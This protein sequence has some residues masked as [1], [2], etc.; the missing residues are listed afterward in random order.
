MY[1]TDFSEDST[2]QQQEDL[3]YDGDLPQMKKCNDYHFTFKNDHLCASGQ[4]ILTGP[5]PQEKPAQNKTFHNSAMA[6]AWDK[7]TKN[8]VYK[9]YN[10]ENPSTMALHI[11]ANK[12]DVSEANISNILYHCLSKEQILRGQ[13]IHCE[14]LPETSSTDSVDEADVIKNIISRCVKKSCHKEQ[15]SEFTG[16][17]KPKRDGANSKKPS[18]SLSVT[19]VTTLGVEEPGAARD[20]GNP[21]SLT[22]IKGPS[23]K[24]RYFRWQV[25]RKQLIEKASSSNGFKDGQGQLHHQDLNVSKVAPKMKTPKN[26]TME[27]PFSIVKQASK[28]P[29]LR[30]KPM[31]LQEVLEATSRSNFVSK[32]HPEQKR[33]KLEPSQQLQME[34]EKYLRQQHTGIEM[35]TNLLKLLSASQKVPSSNSYI[36]LKISQG[37]QMCQKLKEQTD[38]LNT[39]VQEFSKRIKQE[40]PCRVQHRMVREPQLGPLAALGQ[41][42]PATEER[43]PTLQ[44]ILTREPSAMGNFNLESSFIFFFFFFRK[45]KIERRDHGKITCG[46][47]SALTHGKA[48]NQ[49][50]TPE[51]HYRYNTPGQSHLNQSERDAFIQSCSLDRNKNSSPQPKGICSQ[52]V[53]SKLIQDECE[54]TPGKKN[55]KNFMAYSSHLVTPSSYLH[56]CRASRSKALCDLNNV[57]ETNS[58]MLNSALDHALKT[59]TSL[60]KTTDQM[61]KDIAEDLAKAQTWRNRL[62]F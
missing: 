28:S 26:N 23:D 58:K 37:T 61:I 9:N 32:Q 25:L 7:S 18:Y 19:A 11:P 57:E 10:K 48:L 51:F 15:T 36:F 42:S 54:F 22:K 40:S 50:L 14:I 60:K 56:S 55:L 35:E 6:M 24:E 31:A 2:C 8:A 30:M 27:K 43:H 4:L 52:R 46:R 49:A 45:Q 62:K 12:A 53:N 13:G 59:A 20:Q 34:P 5:D 21:H 38:R 1:D 29:S 3:P 47:L 33:K 41:D 44:Q 16:Q 39:K 17:P